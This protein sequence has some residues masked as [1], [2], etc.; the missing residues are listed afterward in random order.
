MRKVEV[1]GGIRS[2]DM[3]RMRSW[4]RSLQITAQERK[5]F[6]D[7]LDHLWNAVRTVQVDFT[8]LATHHDERPPVDLLR[9]GTDSL[10][11]VHA[12]ANNLLSLEGQQALP[13]DQL[14]RLITERKYE[15][16]RLIDL[17]QYFLHV[18]NMVDLEIQTPEESLIDLVPNPNWPEGLSITNIEE[19]EDYLESA[20][21]PE[22]TPGRHN[23]RTSLLY[24][25][26]VLNLRRVHSPAWV[27]RSQQAANLYGPYKSKILLDGSH[28]VLIN[29]ILNRP[30][31]VVEIDVDK[32]MA[33]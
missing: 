1:S 18:G 22:R 27:G 7:R 19:L 12:N 23:D 31:Y 21:N 16:Q 13:L 2:Q 10:F 33:R 26:K 24:Q 30:M 6:L 29:L 28:R 32:A 14:A 15:L 8:Q 11:E 17:R 5:M 3:V 25:L 4:L 9:Y 20:P